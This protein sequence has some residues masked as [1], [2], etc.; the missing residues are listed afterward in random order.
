M[1]TRELTG[2]L[3]TSNPHHHISVHLEDQPLFSERLLA[4]HCHLFRRLFVQSHELDVARPWTHS[5]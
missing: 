1:D 5:I 2:I 4:R 3:I